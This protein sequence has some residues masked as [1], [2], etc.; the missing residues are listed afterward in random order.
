MLMVRVK[1]LPRE[2]K[3]F[4]IVFALLLLMG[5]SPVYAH[6]LDDFF[7]NIKTLS[8]EFTQTS[9]NE[10]SR[11][12]L[13]IDTQNRSIMMHTHTPYEKII[14]LHK[15][16]IISYDVWISSANIMWYQENPLIELLLGN[17]QQEI[18]QID[19]EYYQYGNIILH[20]VDGV[21]TELMSTG[22][23]AINIELHHLVVNPQLEESDFMLT[24]PS[25]VDIID[26]T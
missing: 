5:I 2:I 21:I 9:D 14:L 20:F 8:A 3:M 25:N 23:N 7:A 6:A 15:N 13:L 18:T 4:N 16:K 26:E 22:D 11:G 24:L 19:E 12:I 10:I 17:T 1:S